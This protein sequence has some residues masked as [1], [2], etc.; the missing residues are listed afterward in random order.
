MEIFW[1]AVAGVVIAVGL[2][3][4]FLPGVPGIPLIFAG[5]LISAVASGF[6]F[7]SPI[8]LVILGLL[9]AASVLID[10][11]SGA[12][13]ARWAGAG[14][15]G[16]TAAILGGLFGILAMGPIGIL[17]G[18]AV[19]ALVFALISRRSRGQVVRVVGF[20]LLSTVVGIAVNAL[21]ALVMLIIFIGAIFI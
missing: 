15:W 4:T 7:I 1:H 14:F 10:Y 17:L 2:A 8:T 13:G 18:P 3:G 9:A 21:I 5:Q 12:A 19:G 11:F 20:T 16:A 6:S